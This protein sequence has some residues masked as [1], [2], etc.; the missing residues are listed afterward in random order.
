ML[1][2]R[3]LLTKEI[4]VYEIK[5]ALYGNVKFYLMLVDLKRP[6]QAEDFT[7]LDPE[8]FTSRDNFIKAVIVY[9]KEITELEKEQA[10]EIAS[11]FLENKDDCDWNMEYIKADFKELKKIGVNEL[12]L[13]RQVNNILI[14]AKV[15]KQIEKIDIK[16][17]KYLLQY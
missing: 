7:Y 16:S 11:G 10:Y 15:E 13:I 6:S 9:D 14:A 12:E 3:L 4:E 8:D 2:R 5:K 17:F 1:L